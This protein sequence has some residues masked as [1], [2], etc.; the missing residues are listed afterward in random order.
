MAAPGGYNPYERYRNR[1]MNRVT[2]G[3]VFLA[4]ISAS[5]SVGFWFGRQSAAESVISMRQE[6]EDMHRQR[7]AMQDEIT[8]L[9]AEAQTADLRFQQMKDRMTQEM[10]DGPL[11]QLT[12]LIRQQLADGTDPE[13]L[14]YVIRSGQ[15]PRNCTDPD[16]KRFM[17]STPTYEGSE[18]TVSIAE[19][20]IQI[21]GTGTSA[22][23]AKGEPEAWYDPARP[24]TIVFSI[25]RDGVPEK[26]EKKGPLPIRNTIIYKDREYRFTI[27]EGARSFAKV[28]FD[29]CAYP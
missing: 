29:S 27:A 12:D 8:H 9:S 3:L 26:I 25:D 22:S 24:V 18:S 15:P 23:S 14:A 28:T 4:M 19:G 10:P 5:S 2:R 16:I 13:R 11:R 21:T 7:I 20:A 1:S 6:I 17:I